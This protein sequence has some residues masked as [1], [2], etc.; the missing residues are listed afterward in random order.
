MWSRL[1]LGVAGLACSTNGALQTAGT[2]T[3]TKKATTSCEVFSKNLTA[4]K[5]EFLFQIADRASD[6]KLATEQATKDPKAA[7]ATRQATLDVLREAQP[8]V[9]AEDPKAAKDFETVIGPFDQ[10]LATLD[11]FIEA[12]GGFLPVGAPPDEVKPAQAVL[13]YAAKCKP[14]G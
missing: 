11:K 9:G 14:P 2:T 1:T 12:G 10:H 4:M 7:R 13:D 5:D 6:P 8:L 3:S